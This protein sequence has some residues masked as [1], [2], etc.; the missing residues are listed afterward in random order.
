MVIVLLVILVS[1][2]M[3]EVTTNPDF[4]WTKNG[5]KKYVSN[6]MVKKV[7]VIMKLSQTK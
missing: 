5:T 6:K 7:K 4:N 1:I 3:T 2:Y